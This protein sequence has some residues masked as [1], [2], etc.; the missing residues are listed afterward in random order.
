ME[1]V[2]VHNFFIESYVFTKITGIKVKNVD[3]ETFEFKNI[4]KLIGNYR[5]L[6]IARLYIS[7]ENKEIPFDEKFAESAQDR[8]MIAYHKNPYVIPYE[9]TFNYFDLVFVDRKLHK[10]IA[11]EITQNLLS[12]VFDK[13]VEKIKECAKFIAME[14][15]LPSKTSAIYP[16]ENYD[17][18]FLKK[19]T[20]SGRINEFTEAIQSD[21]SY[22][23]LTHLYYHD[24]KPCVIVIFNRGLYARMVFRL[25][26]LCLC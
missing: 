26:S 13:M 3:W 7:A 19:I 16:I 2:F 8:A 12:K 23:D 6:E 5:L 22:I 10:I 14:H 15:Y 11:K 1:K 9:G 18:V 25:K 20:D 4:M 21:E 24:G 17:V